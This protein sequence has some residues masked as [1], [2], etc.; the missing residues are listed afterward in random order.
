MQKKNSY[1]AEHDLK[2]IIQK[3]SS[4][5][6]KKFYKP[7]ISF[8]S[9]QPQIVSFHNLSIFHSHSFWGIRASSVLIFA[10]YSRGGY[11]ISSM[12]VLE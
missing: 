12:S 10:T 9:G 6:N 1:P 4:Y 11:S 3:W 8:K 2:N 5:G 7:E